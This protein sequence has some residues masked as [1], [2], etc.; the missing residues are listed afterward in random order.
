MEIERTAGE[1]AAAE[2]SRTPLAPLTDRLPALDLRAAYAVQLANAR[3]RAAAGDPIVGHKIGLTAPAMQELFGVHEPDYGHLFK[4]MILRSGEPLPL[5]ELIAPQVEVEPAFILAED[6]RGPGVSADQVLAAT[7]SI[8]PALEII[9]SRIK[10][11]RIRLEDT[12]ADNGSSARVVLG[13]ARL[14]PHETDLADADVVLELDGIAAE[15]GSTRDILGHPAVAV[16][17]LANKLSEFGIYLPA[18]G[19]V[20]PGTCTRSRRLDRPGIAKGR[21]AGLGDV[22][23]ELV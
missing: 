16:A 11:W 12:V 9:D 15:R 6:L 7:E 4:S 8:S 18:G 13:E 1:L 10:D 2:A 23:V 5:T 19:I 20:L 17:W 22:E 21:I 14:A 3:A